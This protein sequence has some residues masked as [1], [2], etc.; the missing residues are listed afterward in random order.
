MNCRVLCSGSDAF[1]G[2]TAMETSVGW[3]DATVR[4]VLPLTEPE[5]AVMVVVPTAIV[6]AK[7]LLLL[8]VAAFAFEEVQL[9]DVKAFMLP[10]L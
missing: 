7:P 3:V 2:A 8:M 5:L 4:V 10:S 1:T 6:V 9:T